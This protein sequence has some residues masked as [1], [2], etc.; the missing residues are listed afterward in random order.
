MI[1]TAL[2]NFLLVQTSLSEQSGFEKAEEAQ[3]SYPG[4]HFKRLS[5]N[6]RILGASESF[7]WLPPLFKKQMYGSNSANKGL[8][9]KA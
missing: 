9:S 5:Y 3:A 7:L 6:N 8:H 2:V 4:L 1:V